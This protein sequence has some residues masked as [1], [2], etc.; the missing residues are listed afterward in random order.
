MIELSNTYLPIKKLPHSPKNWPVGNK[1][2]NQKREN[3][4]LH[5]S[6]TSRRAPTML[7]KLSEIET[8]KTFLPVIFV[9]KM[10]QNSFFGGPL[11]ALDDPDLL[12]RMR[13]SVTEPKSHT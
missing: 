6:S 9:L 2:K 13:A 7:Q 11:S 4:P 8:T 12:F 10:V 5:P 3:Q 1:N